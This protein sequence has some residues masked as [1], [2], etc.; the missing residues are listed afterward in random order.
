M[1]VSHQKLTN[2][3]EILR[4]LSN[5]GLSGSFDFMLDSASLICEPVFSNRVI[6][7]VC[8]EKKDP[9]VCPTFSM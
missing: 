8:A 3:I 2:E 4:R 5:T 7:F 6:D 1:R 9:V